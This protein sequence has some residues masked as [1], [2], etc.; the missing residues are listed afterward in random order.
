MNITIVGGGSIGT[1]FAVHCAKKQHHVTIYTANPERFQ[2]YLSI[3]N[4]TGA[5]IC[6][7]KIA[8][9]TNNP[10]QAFQNADIIFVT[11]PAFAMKNAAD[12]IYP[13]IK[14]DV[15]IGL[16][17]GTGAGEWAF[18]ECLKKHAVLFGMQRV[19]SV[20][21]L[22]R[23]GQSV[24][25]TG[26]RK[27]L[28]VAALP[29]CKTAE[30]SAFISDI[31][32]MP[33][34]P[35]PHYLNLTLIP[36]N[37]I[38]HTARLRTLF[39]DYQKGKVYGSVPLFYEEWTDEA[40]RLLLKCDDEVQRICKA[41]KDCDLSYVKSLKIHYDG[42]TPEQLTKKIS[43]IKSFQ[44]LKTPSLKVNGGYVPDL[45]SRY[46]IA[47]FSFGLEVFVQIADFMETDVPNMKETLSW[48]WNIA[49][50]QSR[51]DFYDFNVHNKQN[52]LELYNQ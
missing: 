22:V 15:K 32:D 31:F 45:H 12:I 33:C 38:L 16:I 10:E 6:K 7:C 37:P 9:I 19:P 41:L 8:D 49:A 21:R 47:D 13:H 5:I 3:V 25:A 24:R 18:R 17:P 29:Q 51:F 44:G 46:F 40:S 36:S 43:S 23:Y 42:D 52:F 26:Y 48:Y 14:K 30:I 20:A 28:H 4:E 50:E 2:H 39:S 27:E 1:Q 11:V 35:L 34:I